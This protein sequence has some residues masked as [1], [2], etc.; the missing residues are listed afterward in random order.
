M[1]LCFDATRFGYGL[2]EAVAMAAE[3][4]LAAI[5]YAFEPFDVSSKE[6]TQL[7]EHEKQHLAEVTQL[8]AE[9]NV[10]IAAL[11]LNYSLNT[12]DKASLKYFR[13]MAAKLG[14]LAEAVSC[15]RIICYLERDQEEGWV[16][17]TESALS[18]VLKDLK[19]IQL[20][21]SLSTPPC[22]RGRS[23]KYWR[24]SDP[25][26]WRDLLAAMPEIS[27]SFSPADCL[28]QGI[29]YLRLLPGI[30]KALEHIEVQDVEINRDMLADS[31][32][33]GPLWWRYRLAGKGQ[34]DWRQL[35]EALKLYE[36][37]GNFSI[38][39]DDEFVVGAESS[40]S[41]ALDSSLKL[42]APLLK[43]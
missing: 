33:F 34:V 27:L 35:I 10:N 42:L 31:G 25:Q 30:V 18:A 11:K 24:P 28:W 1:Q 22:W 17:R 39:L 3:K 15:P 43:Y 7:N 40:L 5:E 16:A 32:M 9:K 13:L 19:K 6:S 14:R 26:E 21:V 20:V 23:L 36:F 8:A 29:D 2:Q 37:Q 41:D 4:G 12:T 38:Q